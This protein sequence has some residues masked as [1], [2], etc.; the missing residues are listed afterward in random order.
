MK[1]SGIIVIIVGIILV[2]LLL[3]SKG[4]PD[5][6]L[7]Q[8][9]VVTEGNSNTMEVPTETQSLSVQENTESQP[10]N[11]QSDSNNNGKSGHQGSRQVSDSRD[12]SQNTT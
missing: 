8:N 6:N 3:F 4:L 12:G 10:L 1:K 7:D 2:A 5:F 11:K 9:N